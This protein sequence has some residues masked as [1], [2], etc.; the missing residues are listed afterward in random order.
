M[1]LILRAA[2]ILVPIHEQVHAEVVWLTGGEVTERG[3]DYVL[4]R[5]GNSHAIRFW[6]YPGEAILYLFLIL[7]SRRLCGFWFG[8]LVPVG[9]LMYFSKDFAR[10]GDSD[11]MYGELIWLA[12][13]ITG[14]FILVRRFSD[15]VERSEPIPTLSAPLRR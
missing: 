4:F 2:N 9:I 10:L 11:M 15:R 13:T 12:C 5:G 14:V 6:G 8:V 7:V 1:G 3:I